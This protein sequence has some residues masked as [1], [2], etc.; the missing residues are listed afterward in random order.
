MLGCLPV[1]RILTWMVL[2]K[3]FGDATALV[4]FAWLLSFLMW[5][6]CGWA[7]LP[8]AS[9]YQLWLTGEKERASCQTLPC[10][11]ALYGL[12]RLRTTFPGGAKPPVGLFAVVLTVWVPNGSN[13]WWRSPLLPRRTYLMSE[14][15]WGWCVFRWWSCYVRRWLD[16]F[17]HSSVCC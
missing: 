3:A 9:A 13:P 7:S 16:E 8:P 17:Q 4:H 10:P 5:G 12:V 1:S 2:G 14:L 15:S 11:V 6:W